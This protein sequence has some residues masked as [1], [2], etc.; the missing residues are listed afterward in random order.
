MTIEHVFR[1]LHDPHLHVD[2]LEGH[3]SQSSYAYFQKMFLASTGN[4]IVSWVT[5]PL[6]RANSCT[7]F[8]CCC[9]IWV[10]ESQNTCIWAIF[11][12]NSF[13]TLA[14]NEYLVSLTIVPWLSSPWVFKCLVFSHINIHKIPSWYGFFATKVCWHPHLMEFPAR[15]VP[16]HFAFDANVLFTWKESYSCM[17]FL[18]RFCFWVW[19]FFL[20]FYVHFSSVC[21][22]C[23]A[24]HVLSS[25]PKL[26]LCLLDPMKMMIQCI[27]GE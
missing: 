19:T 15:V 6:E 22:S 17:T 9:M 16:M 11:I 27:G 26:N 1:V 14:P 5:T 23:G 13:E 24:I 12:F 3:F 18:P 25:W 21:M 20:V 7:S 10:G 4:R 8:M 2:W